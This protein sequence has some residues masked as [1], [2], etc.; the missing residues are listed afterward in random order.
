MSC[1][2]TCVRSMARDLRISEPTLVV[3]TVVERCVRMIK[4]IIAQP[5]IRARHEQAPLLREREQY[6]AH[7]AQQGTNHQQIQSVAAILL[8]VVHFM[9]LSELRSVR[10]EEIQKAGEL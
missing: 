9:E 10:R 7:L 4:N 6:L 1:N 2:N 8:N 5:S 3:A